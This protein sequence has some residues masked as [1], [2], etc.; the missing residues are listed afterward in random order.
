[1]W[2]DALEDYWEFY[3]VWIC[4]LFV[5]IQDKK[6]TMFFTL[7]F[8][9]KYRS[10]LLHLAFPDGGQERER[11]RPFDFHQT[12]MKCPVPIARL[13]TSV[14]PGLTHSPFW[15]SNWGLLP[16]P[17]IHFHKVCST[18]MSFSPLPN[19]AERN[20][21]K[22]SCLFKKKKKLNWKIKGG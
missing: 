21:D 22:K 13:Y 11:E 1:M 7:S 6:C 15:D 12:V 17:T 3:L 14:H 10:E 5:Q 4:V 2:R 19:S 9:G 16:L 8:C 20:K 18:P